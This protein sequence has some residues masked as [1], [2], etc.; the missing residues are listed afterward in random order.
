[1]NRFQRAD[2]EMLKKKILY[3]L[4]VAIT[5]RIFSF[6]ISKFTEKSY[7]YFISILEDVC[8]V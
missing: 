4:F 5:K 1:M 7:T 8:V 2:F 6:Y 3:L